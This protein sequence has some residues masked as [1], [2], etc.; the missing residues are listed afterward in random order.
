MFNA[1]VK[2]RKYRAG[3]IED[4]MDSEFFTTLI[5]NKANEFMEIMG[6]EKGLEQ[7]Q[8]NFNLVYGAMGAGYLLAMSNMQEGTVSSC[9]LEDLEVP[10]GK[11]R[12][13]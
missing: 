7:T 4:L 13:N 11:T 10:G 2:G 1:T 8:D 9:T 5:S 12:S 3:T 6:K